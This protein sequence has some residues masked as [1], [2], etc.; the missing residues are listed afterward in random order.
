MS[1]PD[2]VHPAPLL[3]ALR[4]VVAW[5][6]SPA[7]AHRPRDLADIEGLLEARPDVDLAE[8]RKTVREFSELLEM[9]EIATSFEEVVRRVRGPSRQ[10]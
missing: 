4:D 8:A 6:A 7:V 5:F 1:S 3:A 2:A 9:P 10:K